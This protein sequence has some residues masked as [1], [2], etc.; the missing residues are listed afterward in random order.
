MRNRSARASRRGSYATGPCCGHFLARRFEIAAK[1]RL[2][3][4]ACEYGGCEHTTLLDVARPMHIADLA[5][6]TEVDAAAD[7]GIGSIRA[8]LARI[9]PQPKP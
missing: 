8:T 7:H 5:A 6:V 4:Q 9:R 2:G 1:L 3:L